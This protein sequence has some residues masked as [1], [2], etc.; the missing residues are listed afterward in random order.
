M[1][2]LEPRAIVRRFWEEVWQKGN[3]AVIDELV[4]ANYVRYGPGVLQGECRG[5]AALKS[6]VQTWRAALPDLQVCV[7][8]VLDDGDEVACRL[9]WRGHQDGPLLGRSPTGREVKMWEIQSCRV[10]D[11]KIAEF[12]ATFDR[13]SILDQLGAEFKWETVKE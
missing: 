13:L 1:A 4:A 6:V 9:S 3:L 5:L 8:S 11:G 12:W 7:E 2:T 10:V